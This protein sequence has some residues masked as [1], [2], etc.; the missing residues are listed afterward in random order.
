MKLLNVYSLED[1]DHLVKPDE[2][3]DIN[4]DSPALS[5]LSDFRTH[6]PHTVGAHVPAV[7]AAHLMAEAKVDLKL[8]IDSHGEMVGLITRELL[9]DQRI[10]VAQA[11]RGLAHEEVLVADMMQPRAHIHA[12][13]LQALA[14][15]KVSDILKAMK[16][17]G[18]SHYLVL[19]RNRHQIRGVISLKAL[20]RRLDRPVY[21]QQAPATVLDMLSAVRY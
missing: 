3:A 17:H 8:V 12:I 6:F 21:V 14:R 1:R 7:D 11:T 20:I 9:S 13:D 16:D 5:I 10:L 18:E 4:G 19:D 15:A 2:F